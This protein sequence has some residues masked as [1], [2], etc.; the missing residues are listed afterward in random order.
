[1]KHLAWLLVAATLTCPALADDFK[2][3]LGAGATWPVWSLI[4][5]EA[6][7]DYKTGWLVTGRALWIPKT[8]S[9]GVRVAGYYGQIPVTSG[10]ALGEAESTLAGGGADLNLAVRL[11][12]KGADGI[13][14]NVGIGF[15][16]LRQEL[17]N[18]NSQKLTF[19]DTNISYNG[20]FGVSL[21]PAFGEVNIVYFKAQNFEF[22]ALP[23]TI[24][25]Q[26]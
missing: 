24:G 11:V 18:G 16:T 1:M 22:L 20:G 9:L 26:F 3:G 21:G 14:L 13:Y 23:V 6:P 12:G 10:I 5:G 17:E 15:R 2:F 8:S 19:S 4:T 7:V 25:L